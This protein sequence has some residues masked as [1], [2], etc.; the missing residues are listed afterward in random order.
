LEN[1]KTSGCM[2]FKKYL[3]V[4]D[5]IGIVGDLNLIGSTNFLVIILK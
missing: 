4:T 2:G 1:D 5:K 3:R